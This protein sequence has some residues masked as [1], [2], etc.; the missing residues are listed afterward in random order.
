MYWVVRISHDIQAD[1]EA[2][3]T[4]FVTAETPLE[5]ARTMVA[6]LALEAAELN[7]P[8]TVDDA[9]EALEQAGLDV[10]RRPDGRWG[11]FDHDGLSAW[12]NPEIQGLD[13]IR[14][15]LDDVLADTP[16]SGTREVV[17]YPDDV[18]E[19]HEVADGVYAIRVKDFWGVF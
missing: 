18:L 19:V 5:L 2:G 6:Q 1:L 14:Q 17:F 15:R 4:C 8:E 16:G 9:L 13:A 10:R 12:F 3:F 7:Q 11:I